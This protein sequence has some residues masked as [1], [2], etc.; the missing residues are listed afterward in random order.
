MLI[1]G[2]TH[3]TMSSDAKKRA[4]NQ[5]NS[6]ASHDKNTHQIRKN[7]TS[8]TD[9]GHLMRLPTEK[10]GVGRLVPGSE[11][12]DGQTLRLARKT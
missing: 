9:K 2:K 6:T 12:R 4:Y 8:S 5:Q 7:G 3:K 1:K 10:L 11:A